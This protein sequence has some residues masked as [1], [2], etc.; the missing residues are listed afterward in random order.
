M[1][2]PSEDESNDEDLKLESTKRIRLVECILPILL[3]ILVVDKFWFIQQTSTFVKASELNIIKRDFGALKREVLES[4]TD[5]TELNGKNDRIVDELS[6]IDETQ[7]EIN[8]RLAVMEEEIAALLSLKKE[9]VTESYYRYPEKKL[10]SNDFSSKGLV[11][12]S[13]SQVEEI[14]NRKLESHGKNRHC[15]TIP[16][17]SPINE[18]DGFIYDTRIAK[19]LDTLYAISPLDS[20]NQMTSPQYKAACWILYDDERK[21]E[22][23][24][25]FL[26]QR[27]VLSMFLFATHENALELLHWNICDYVGFSCNDKGHV[28]K[29]DSRKS[30]MLKKEST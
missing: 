20:I 9:Y 3:V 14:P 23:D 5:I 7:S 21:M 11:K 19:I 27:Y 1:K 26:I 28:V 18:V 13:N 15:D 24:D 12:S 2:S 25:Q 29:I 30:P 8:K 10:S 17:L 4:S 22:P 16:V 6:Q